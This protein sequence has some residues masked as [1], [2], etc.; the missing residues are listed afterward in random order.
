[1]T[2]CSG[3]SAIIIQKTTS[4]SPSNRNSLQFDLFDI[5]NKQD[6]ALQIMS[7]CIWRKIEWRLKRIRWLG[8]MIGFRKW[9]ERPL[10]LIVLFIRGSVLLTI[11][12][13]ALCGSRDIYIISA[14]KSDDLHYTTTQHISARHNTTHFNTTRHNTTQHNTDSTA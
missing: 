13:I 3:A 8:F 1:M 4:S 11:D 10:Y 12:E 5:A 14:S 9:V 2:L 7:D 6:T